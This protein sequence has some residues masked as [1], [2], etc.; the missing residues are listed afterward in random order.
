MALG[1]LPTLL[2]WNGPPIV[3]TLVGASIALVAVELSARRQRR[4]AD[5]SAR[6]EIYI[7]VIRELDKA[8]LHFGEFGPDDDEAEAFRLMVESQRSLSAFDLIGSEKVK[9]VSRE[10]N[11]ERH[12][13]L[14]KLS[15]ALRSKDGDGAPQVRYAY[16]E[17][18]KRGRNRLLEAMQEDLNG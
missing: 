4:E 15:A 12:E 13:E 2:G 8:A 17:A 1:G 5:R 14:V 16:A 3:Q 7:E 18:I 11:A 10:I 9:K 6:R